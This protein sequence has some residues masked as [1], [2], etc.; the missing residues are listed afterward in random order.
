MRS[1]A[2]LCSWQPQS[3]RLR[4]VRLVVTRIAHHSGLERAG[5]MEALR[6]LDR[7]FARIDSGAATLGRRQIARESGTFGARNGL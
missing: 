1:P 3:P 6:K 4:P 2:D 5:T 7:Q